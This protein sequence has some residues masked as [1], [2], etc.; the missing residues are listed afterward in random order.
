MWRGV[1]D[2][3]GDI[4]VMFTIYLLHQAK[5][6]LKSDP[7]KFSIMKVMFAILCVDYV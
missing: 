6:Y 3:V 2:G 1:V 7:L 5:V 4:G